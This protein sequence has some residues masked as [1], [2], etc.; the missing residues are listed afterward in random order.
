MQRQTL[1]TLTYDQFTS[2][3]LDST[4]CEVLTNIHYVITPHLYHTT[5]NTSPW[6]T[7]AEITKVIQ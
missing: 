5:I 3:D 1:G 4:N 7:G 2:K 6:C